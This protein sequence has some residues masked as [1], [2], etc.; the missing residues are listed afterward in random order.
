MLSS[1]HKHPFYLRA[2]PC[3][4]LEPPLNASVAKEVP[5]PQCRQT[6]VPS[7][8]PLLKADCTGIS[9]LLIHTYNRNWWLWFLWWGSLGLKIK[10]KPQLFQKMQHLSYIISLQ[11]HL[12][13]LTCFCWTSASSPWLS[14]SAEAW[15]KTWG[16]SAW[17]WLETKESSA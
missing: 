12:V 16:S 6:V 11:K 8:G 3:L 1:V 4:S 13:H 7:I 17:T 10:K 5:T 9:F 2:L 14:C 15:D